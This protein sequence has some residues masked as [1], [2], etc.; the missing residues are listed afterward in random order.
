MRK[1]TAWLRYSE[2]I[3]HAGRTSQLTRPSAGT[4]KIYDVEMMIVCILSMENNIV[5]YLNQVPN[6]HS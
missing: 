6:P 2:I 1:S 5:Q 4:L 3:L